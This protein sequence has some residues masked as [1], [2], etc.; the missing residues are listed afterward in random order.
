MKQTSLIQE[1]HTYYA[2]LGGG[3]WVELGL[4]RYHS[5]F[6]N[7]S[8]K[9]KSTITHPSQYNNGLSAPDPAMPRQR[10]QTSHYTSIHVTPKRRWRWT[11]DPPNRPNS[12]RQ[13]KQ[14]HPYNSTSNKEHYCSKISTKHTNVHHAHTLK[15]TIFYFET[16]V[17]SCFG[18]PA[19]MELGV[20]P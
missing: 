16:S 3:A 14:H 17:Q 13:N 19:N 8:E 18:L 9:K 7:K 12:E 2:T 11:F 1:Q 15:C 5:T 20:W 6:T 10:A 4:E